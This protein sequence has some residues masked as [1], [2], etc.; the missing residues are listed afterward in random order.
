MLEVYNNLEFWWN[1]TCWGLQGTIYG[2]L[3]LCKWAI[4]YLFVKLTHIFLTLPLLTIPN[5]IS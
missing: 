5:T 2:L 3:K 1:L 4:A